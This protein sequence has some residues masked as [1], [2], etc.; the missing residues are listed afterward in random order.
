MPGTFTAVD[1]SRLPFPAVVEP[2]DYERIRA[3]MLDD[4]RQRWPAFDALLESDP[5]VKVLEVAAYRELL[6]RARINDA[7]K[8]VTLAYASGSDLD[9]IASLFGVTRLL[10]TPA[11]P[12][13]TPPR[14]AVYESDDDLRRR[15]Q[16][17]FEGFSTAGPDGAYLFH[18]LSA[19]GQVLDASVDS[20]A[21]GEVVIS[22]LS[23]TGDGT[24]SPA[25]I[26]TVQAALSA[27]DVRPLTDHV[28]VLGAQIVPYVVS[29]TLTLYP[30]PDAAVVLADARA[31]LASHV[32][33]H[34][35]LGRDITRAGL[36][37]ALCTAGVQNVLLESPADDIVITLRQAAWCTST[38]IRIGGVDE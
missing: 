36:I 21:P 5:A 38:D 14:P 33:E 29:A 35:R 22:V 17:A 16:L 30:G 27:E 20:P 26:A 11:N 6:L 34:H 15:V 4:L 7:A 32:A 23:R 12:Q 25:L 13:A 18:A 9:H 19:D 10:V 31:R 1:L 2:L 37:A 24:A 8:A 28:V 3:A